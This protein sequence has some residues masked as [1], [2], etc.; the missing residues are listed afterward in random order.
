MCT[1]SDEVRGAEGGSTFAGFSAHGEDRTFVDE[2]DEE[3]G[4]GA[5]RLAAKVA[6]CATNGVLGEPHLAPLIHLAQGL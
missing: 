1:P 6:G 5:T 3:G 4:A 2:T